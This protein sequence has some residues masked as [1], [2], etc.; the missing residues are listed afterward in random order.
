MRQAQLQV[1]AQSQEALRQETAT[2]C[3]TSCLCC[4]SDSHCWDNQDH[5]DTRALNHTG[6]CTSG[7]DKYVKFQSECVFNAVF[8][9][10]VNRLASEQ[11]STNPEIFMN[12]KVSTGDRRVLFYALGREG[13]ARDFTRLERCSYPFILVN[14]CHWSQ[15]NIVS[16]KCCI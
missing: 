11:L 9:K 8:K 12:G 15:R 5:T 6:A 3:T 2:S 10:R 13:V 7:C 16:L 14:T 4:T 1:W